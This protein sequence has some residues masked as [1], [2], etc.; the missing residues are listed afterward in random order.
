MK[1]REVYEF[2]MQ[3]DYFDEE[4]REEL[5]RISNDPDEIEER[6]YRDLEFGTGAFGAQSEQVR[7]G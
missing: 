6:F 2:W 7:T 4:T 3:N 1:S 5:A